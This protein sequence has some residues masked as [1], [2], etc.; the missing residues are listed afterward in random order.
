MNTFSH[1]ETFKTVKMISLT[2]CAILAVIIGSSTSFQ[3]EGDRIID[4]QTAKP[5]QFPYQVSLRV[6]YLVGHD[7]AY[8]HYCGGSIISNRWILSAAHCMDGK[9][10]TPS[11][12]LVY[13]GAH[14]YKNDGRRYFLSKI[15]KHPKYDWR[16]LKNDV[17]LLQTVETIQFSA[18]VKPIQLSKGFV[19][20]GVVATVSG[21]GW[22]RVR[23]MF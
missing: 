1:S 11:N 19:N 16:I 20:K 2:I 7:I 13:I 15:V 10:S 5:G 4:G 22:N 3:L 9:Y 18:T 23:K 6:P 14:H 21:W 12:I 17:G 8:A